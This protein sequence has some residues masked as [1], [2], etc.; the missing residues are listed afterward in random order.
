MSQYY[1]ILLYGMLLCGC[2]G[3]IYSTS[4]YTPFGRYEEERYKQ[5]IVI[6]IA[7][8]SIPLVIY[9]PTLYYTR[10]ASLLFVNRT[11]FVDEFE[12]GTS[13]I[14]I[15]P[16]DPLQQYNRSM[17]AFNSTIYQV[18]FAPFMKTYLLITPKEV[19]QGI[20]NVL[21]NA[22]APL[23]MIL[24]ILMGDVKNAGIEFSKFV[25]NTTAG[26]LGFVDI[27]HKDTPQ[28]YRKVDLDD[29]FQRWGIPSGPY[30]VLPLIGGRTLRG[31]VA[32][33]LESAMNPLRYAIPVP[34]LF[35]SLSSIRIVSS[36]S[37]YF[38]LF[39]MLEKTSV[40]PYVAQREIFW[41]YMKQ[42]HEMQ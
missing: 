1:I 38:D 14:S 37:Q 3:S 30:I 17:Y 15:T 36:G 2:T 33:P 9:K 21:S 32:L 10:P 35:T 28:T 13:I 23:R 11:Q 42:R 34:A 25:V 27:T 41:Q 4:S 40:D 16:Q 5:D 31:A 24:N 6:G 29:V 19:R 18:V 39:Y 26:F 7:K 20:R 12:E 22:L 8:Y